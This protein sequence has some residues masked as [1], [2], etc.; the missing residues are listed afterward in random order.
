MELSKYFN[1]NSLV[2][3]FN[4]NKCIA[5][6]LLHISVIAGAGEQSSN[7][8]QSLSDT[9]GSNLPKNGG[10]TKLMTFSK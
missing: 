2:L 3:I 1:V 7:S 4:M 9:P 10:K 6:A 5:F 8:D